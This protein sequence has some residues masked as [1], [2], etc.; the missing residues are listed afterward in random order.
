MKEWTHADLV[1]RGARWL[2]RSLKCSPVL[3]ETTSYSGEIPD[4]I[5]WKPAT[6]RSFVLECKTSRGD[7]RADA[8]KTHRRNPDLALGAERWYFTPAGL[9]KPEEIPPD[10]GLAE[11]K[12]ND[13]HV[14]VPARPRKDL[15][16]DM[17]KSYELSLLAT[18][19]H[20]MA[21]RVLPAKLRDWVKWE[22]RDITL[23]EMQRLAQEETL[24][25]NVRTTEFAYFTPEELSQLM[26]DAQ[27]KMYFRSTDGI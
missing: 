18:T 14:V 12:G 7:F 22:C 21:Y 1:E 11:V 2:E 9:L 4:V 19:L 25:E 17:A 8:E 3:T 27:R 24:P 15:R 13:V 26:S 10:W 16:S 6:G 20:R 5:G 23:E